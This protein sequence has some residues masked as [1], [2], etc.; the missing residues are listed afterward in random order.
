MLE[1]LARVKARLGSGD[2][3][4]SRSAAERAAE[5]VLKLLPKRVLA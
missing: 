2:P 3:T 4:D 5:V 1:G